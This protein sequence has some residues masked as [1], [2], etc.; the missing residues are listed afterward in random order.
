MHQAC[1]P[2]SLLAT[3]AACLWLAITPSA[4]AAIPSAFNQTATPVPCGV[5][6]NGV[7]LCDESAFSPAL[8][9]S[10]VKTFDG[11]PIDVR[12]A[13]PAQP[14]NGPDGPYPLMMLFH[15]YGDQKLPLQ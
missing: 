10:T 9:R 11:V 5:L 2:A 4:H 6:P 13:F 14:A 12:V 1:R 3:A 15:G 8:P 7:R